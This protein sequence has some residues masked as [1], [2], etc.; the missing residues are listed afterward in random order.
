MLQ[1]GL[2]ES[3]PPPFY[4]RGLTPTLIH[5]GLN[6]VGIISKGP[7]H[8]ESNVTEPGFKRLLALPHITLQNHPQIQLQRCPKK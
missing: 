2:A 1:P 7:V 4:A 6:I 5:F 3:H 8:G